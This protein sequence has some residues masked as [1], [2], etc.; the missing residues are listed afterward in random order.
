[1]LA[2][3]VGDYL[4]QS[5]WMAD[6]KVKRWWPALVHGAFYT[7]PFLWITLDWRALAVI[8]LTHVVIDRFRLAKRITWLKN[9]IAP[10]RVWRSDE[11][12]VRWEWSSANARWADAKK[13]AGAPPETPAYISFWVM[14]IV[15]NT[16]HLLINVWAVQTFG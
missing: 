11:L 12:G 5:Q 2:H 1:M 3:L 14:V 4:L 10:L 7:V 13:N 9:W 16:I 8:G 15:D 6:Q